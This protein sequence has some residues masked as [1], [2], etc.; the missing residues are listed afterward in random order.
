[1]KV[2]FKSEQKIILRKMGGAGRESRLAE[3]AK[4][5]GLVVGAS[6]VGDLSGIPYDWRVSCSQWIRVGNAIL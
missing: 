6:L 2:D 5:E 3:F 4:G 1:M